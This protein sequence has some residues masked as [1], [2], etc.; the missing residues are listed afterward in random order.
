MISRQLFLPVKVESYIVTP[1]KHSHSL[2]LVDM[3]SFYPPTPGSILVGWEGSEPGREVTA[4]HVFSANG[5][6]QHPWHPAV[7]REQMP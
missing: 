3:K 7:L 2:M 6:E 5:R 4:S 1:N